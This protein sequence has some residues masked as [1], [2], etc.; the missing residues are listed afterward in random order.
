MRSRSGD[1]AV[2]ETYNLQ[3]ASS[4]AKQSNLVLICKSRRDFFISVFL[5][6]TRYFMIVP[7]IAAILL[8]TSAHASERQRCVRAEIVLWGDGR[9]DD[10]AALNAWFRGEPATWA[11]SGE[12][13]GASIAGHSFRLS[14]PVYVPGGPA[15][16]LENFRMVWPERGETVSGGMILSGSDADQAPI[17]SGV[18]IRGGDPGEGIPFET[19][20]PVSTG[21]DEEASCGTS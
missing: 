10:S 20:D 12:P 6:A 18:S 16:R 14:A 1:I 13:V 9:H 8:Q 3:A 15:R 7:A 4:R 2:C 19:Q 17:L 21:R 5:A 11:N